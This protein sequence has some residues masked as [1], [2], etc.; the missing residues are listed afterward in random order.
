MKAID[1]FGSVAGTWVEGDPALGLPATRFSAKWGNAVQAELLAVLAAANIAPD[2]TNNAQVLQALNVLFGAGNSAVALKN[3]TI[4]GGFDLW[5]RGTTFAVTSTV[6]SYTA[7]RWLVIA[8]G[9]TGA[10]TATV[11][12]QPH[13]VGQTDVPNSPSYFFRYQQTVA[14]TLGAPNIATLLEDVSA[15]SDGQVT[16]SFYAKASSAI[17][18]AIRAVQRF[19]PNGTGGSPD[20]QL[21]SST[22]SI[23]TSWQRFTATFACAST[24]GKTIV[25]GSHL[26]AG[27][28]LP[29]SGTFTL[30]ISDFQV[31]RSGAVSPFDRRPLQV[32]QLLAGRYFQKS[33][34]PQVDPG[35]TDRTGAS[36]GL[37]SQ[38]NEAPTG[39]Q[40]ASDLATEFL[41]P[42]RATPTI[43]WYSSQGG[44]PSLNVGKIDS[45][46]GGVLAQ[47]TVTL[48]SNAGPLSTGFPRFAWAT[49]VTAPYAVWGQWTADAELI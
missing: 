8:G 45:L 13:A 3:K 49:T 38:F 14:A 43:V 23:A 46:I 47:Q 20:V 31:E 41:V 35:A 11:T 39:S 37:V 30:D 12:R 10:G 6:S 7:D 1:S 9:L 26:R 4:N 24:S 28:N 44:T 40:D 21:G 27:L 34:Q 48:N 42:M 5:N 22:I 16:V 32:E 19:G 25:A 18:A 29:A 15:Y 2:E 36:F 17:S 33:F